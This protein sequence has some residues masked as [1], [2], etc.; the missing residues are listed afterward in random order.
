MTRQTMTKDL[1]AKI[2]DAYAE[3][4]FGSKSDAMIKVGMPPKYAK[5][6]SGYK[7]FQNTMVQEAIQALVD[8]SPAAEDIDIDSII[9]GLSKMAFPKKGDNVSHANRIAAMDKLAKIRQAY[10]DGAADTENQEK[11]RARMS[12]EEV[13]F[14]QFYAEMRCDE[15]SHP[16]RTPEQRGIF[17][18]G[19]VIEARSRFPDFVLSEEQSN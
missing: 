1:A 17:K 19:K 15:I 6:G 9:A 16:E 7:M 8:G 4:G 18:D 13:V 3:S 14:R 12:D 11:I 2:A 5:S 10:R